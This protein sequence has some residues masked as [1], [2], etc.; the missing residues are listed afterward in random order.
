MLR[1]ALLHSRSIHTLPCCQDNVLG[2]HCLALSAVPPA[3]CDC[4]KGNTA[5]LHG[6]WGKADL[7]V[8][9]AMLAAVH[10]LHDIID[11]KDP[12]HKTV[13]V[14]ACLSADAVSLVHNAARPL[15]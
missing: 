13:D 10:S 3:Q 7:A 15:L 2:V 6:A 5:M 8:L 11:S 14:Q 1:V 9:M 4:L 12:H